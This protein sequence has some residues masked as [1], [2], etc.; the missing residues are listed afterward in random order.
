VRLGRVVG[1]VW[2][3]AKTPQLEGRTLLVIQPITPDGKDTGRK[4]IA[5]DAIG[6]GAGETIYWSR[7]R[8][9]SYAF[10]PDEV[11]ADAAVVAIVD[12]VDVYKTKR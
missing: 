7:G 3:T 9:A 2:A 5:V 4:L 6:A 1:S 11:S 10:L 8:E 12:T